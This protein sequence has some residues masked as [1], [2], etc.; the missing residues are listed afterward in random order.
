MSSGD[1]IEDLF[2]STAEFDI[3]GMTRMFDAMNV[4]G[5]IHNIMTTNFE[6][7]P[8]HLFSPEMGGFGES[9]R[10]KTGEQMFLRVRSFM[11]HSAVRGR[12][13]E[14]LVV[15]EKREISVVLMRHEKPR[16]LGTMNVLFAHLPPFPTN[17]STLMQTTGGVFGLNTCPIVLIDRFKRNLT[18]SIQSIQNCPCLF[19]GTSNVVAPNGSASLRKGPQW[20]SIV[21]W[22]AGVH[23]INLHKVGIVSNYTER[24]YDDMS[25][26][27]CH[28]VIRHLEKE[29]T[30][31]TGN[32]SSSSSGQ[33]N[34][35]KRN[36]PDVEVIK[37]GKLAS[38][39]CE[40]ASLCGLVDLVTSGT[41]D[42]LRLQFFNK[43][44][45]FPLYVSMCVLLAG[46][47]EL[48][49]FAA[50]TPDDQYAT[51]QVI[52]EYVSATYSC[53]N[54]KSDLSALEQLLF[55]CD[56]SS[57]EMPSGVVHM[58]RQGI[59]LCS[60]LCGLP[61]QELINSDTEA[62]QN[63][64]GGDVLGTA[65]EDV[66]CA[67]IS[68]VSE[69][70]RA[71]NVVGGERG[72]PPR[73]LRSSHKS[74]ILREVITTMVNTNEWIATGIFKMTRMSRENSEIEDATIG[75]QYN[76]DASTNAK[77][78]VAQYYE[79]GPAVLTNNACF[80]SIPIT[81]NTLLE[82]GECSEMFRA[83]NTLTRSRFCACGN[84]SV[85]FCNNCY[86]SKVS[87]LFVA[88][89]GKVP[90]TLLAIKTPKLWHCRFCSSKL[91]K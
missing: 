68:N 31:P 32:P 5:A 19:L 28:K 87:A 13:F 59:A 24:A 75:V 4:P 79:H 81:T 56:I 63:F 38:L 51:S 43:P 44:T 57:R 52:A 62:M 65:L 22:F 85:F 73:Q 80:L 46:R 41:L 33:I 55:S 10:L 58:Q 53:T 67:S 9:I 18:Q 54:Y 49:G 30:H 37:F 69:T 15:G 14:T 83:T 23:N 40:F 35:E 74:A 77:T 64:L 71:K 34:V 50:P 7:E 61:S 21:Q 42:G 29:R 3:E 16:Q 66:L 26:S 88:S 82:C 8:A 1:T 72:E 17:R 47:P 86:A 76:Y 27:S 6:L 39:T 11:K 90:E 89:G 84:C 48:Y 2:Q 70:A 36:A 20:L 12:A 78:F 45:L 60:E 25:T 91:K